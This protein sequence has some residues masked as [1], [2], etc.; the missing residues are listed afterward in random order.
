VR[1]EPAGIHVQLA[2]IGPHD[3]GPGIVFPAGPATMV[4]PQTEYAAF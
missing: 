1:G 2:E 3:P 4:S